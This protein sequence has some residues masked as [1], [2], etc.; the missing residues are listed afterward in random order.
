MLAL[1]VLRSGGTSDNLNQ[2]AGNDGLAGTV[3]ENLVPLDHVTSVL[4]GVLGFV[5]DDSKVL[6]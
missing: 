5:S 1:H 3:E 6:I 2:L 4:G